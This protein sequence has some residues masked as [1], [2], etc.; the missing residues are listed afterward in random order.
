LTVILAR[1]VW[2]APSALIAIKVDDADERLTA[3]ETTVLSWAGMRGV[4]TLAAAFILP[5]DFPDREVLVFAAMV[6]V[7]GS[8]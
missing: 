6:V 7:A 2:C 8:L 3:G 5:L 1:M 4:V